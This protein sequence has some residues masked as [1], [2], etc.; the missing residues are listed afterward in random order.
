MPLLLVIFTIHVRQN[1]H[2][3]LQL[4]VWVIFSLH[5]TIKSNVNL[6]YK[7]PNLHIIKPQYLLVFM[8][9]ALLLLFVDTTIIRSGSRRLG[10]CL[11]LLV[12]SYLTLNQKEEKKNKKPKQQFQNSDQS[13]FS[14]IS[15]WTL[16]QNPLRGIDQSFPRWKPISF[17]LFFFHLLPSFF[18]NFRFVKPS[19]LELKTLSSSNIRLS[20][21]RIIL[22]SR[23][24]M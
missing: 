20:L 12:N 23:Y 17:P 11:P 5:V 9:L 15:A 2:G 16:C 19:L 22:L 21:L 13:K 4:F 18:V 3:P 10:R 1:D 6:Y 14:S 8:C 7:S 24:V